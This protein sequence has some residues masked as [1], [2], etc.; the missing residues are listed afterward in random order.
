MDE[1]ITNEE[2][3]D[4]TQKQNENGEV[5]ELEDFE[6]AQTAGG[7]IFHAT[8]AAYDRRNRYEVIN[9]KGEA[10]ARFGSWDEAKDYCNKKNITSNRIWF[11]NTIRKMR[12]AY[13]N[14]EKYLPDLK[15]W[16]NPYGHNWYS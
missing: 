6:L 14:K 2:T 5:S 3:I 9:D 13:N 1:T 16:T 8:G 4:Q 12:N 10:E 11:Y 15:N 7:G